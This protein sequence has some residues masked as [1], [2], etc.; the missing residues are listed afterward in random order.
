MTHSNS[1]HEI[2]TLPQKSNWELRLAHWM[3][4]CTA[5]EPRNFSVLL[6]WADFGML[7]A[8]KSL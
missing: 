7:K 5:E 6:S 3:D 1:F 2:K 4:K 8:L